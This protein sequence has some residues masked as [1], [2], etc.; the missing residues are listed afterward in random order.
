[1]NILDR[2]EREQTV[3]PGRLDVARVQ[4]REEYAQ[5]Q[6]RPVAAKPVAVRADFSGGS[7]VTWMWQ[8]CH[9]WLLSAEQPDVGRL[10]CVGVYSVT[11]TA[12]PPS[13]DQIRVALGTVATL[14]LP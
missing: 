11:F 12:R 2:D 6:T 7:S 1:V 4:R 8:G 5:L 13:I 14:H 10:T 3:A 9:L